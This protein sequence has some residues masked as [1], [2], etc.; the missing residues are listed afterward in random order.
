MYEFEKMPG[1]E[2]VLIS[3]ESVLKKDGKDKGISTILTNQRLLLLDYPSA[4]NNYKEALKSRGASYIMR[5]EVILAVDL[6]DIVRVE[7]DENYDKYV[8]ANTNYFY[9]RDDQIRDAFKKL[10]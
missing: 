10:Q 8:M 3:N 9:L 2:I 6:Q 4:V 5:K 1:E 7:T